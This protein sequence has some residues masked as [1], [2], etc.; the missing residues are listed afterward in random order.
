[1][2]LYF[3]RQAEQPIVMLGLNILIGWPFY[4]P[5]PSTDDINTY[6]YI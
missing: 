5:K 3:D 6:K 4:G 2:H 1:M